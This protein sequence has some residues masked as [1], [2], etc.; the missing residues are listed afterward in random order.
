MS[1]DKRTQGNVSLDIKEGVGTITFF[2]PSHNSLPGKLLAALA[3]TIT[4]CGTN[5]SIKVIVLKSE[6]DRTFCAGASFDELVAIEN[7]AAGK[8]FFS[9]FANVINAC[10]KCP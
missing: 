3:D 4:R 8:T 7:E 2:H 9:G 10:R 6:G 1:E 5:D